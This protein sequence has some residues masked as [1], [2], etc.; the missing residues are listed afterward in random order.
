[1]LTRALHLLGAGRREYPL[2]F[3]K[4]GLKRVQLLFTRNLSPLQSLKFSFEYL[5]LPPRSALEAVLPGVTPKAS[6]R[7]S[8]PAYSLRHKPC[9]SGGLWVTRLSA[10]HFQEESQSTVIALMFESSQEVISCW[11]ALFLTMTLHHRLHQTILRLTT[12]CFEVHQ[13]RTG[14]RM[15]LY[16]SGDFTAGGIVHTKI[17]R[18]L[19]AQIQ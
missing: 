12:I 15:L 19:F 8:T 10:I 5:L 16:C 9:P 17:W 7:T 13:Y 1:V 18:P 14:S 2:V 11:S 4:R 6:P 3:G